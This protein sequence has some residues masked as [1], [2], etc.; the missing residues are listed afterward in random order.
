MR[1]YV[2]NLA[3]SPDRR[4]HMTAELQKVG[5]PYEFVDGV[6]GQDLD[7][8]DPQV[9]HPS[10]LKPGWPSPGTAGCAFGHLRAYE[11]IL[12]DDLD[13][14]LVL[15]D[16]VILPN[17]LADLAETVAGRMS[18]AEVAL[19]H[20]LSPNL[21]KMNRRGLVQLP[22]SRQLV[23]PV[24]VNEPGS[25]AAYIITRDACKRMAECIVPFRAHADDWGHFFNQGALDRVRCVLPF[26][27]VSEPSFGSTIGY[28]KPSG[29]K[30]RV[31][32]VAMKYEI[33]FIKR[34]I[35]YRRTRI[36]RKL[37]RF[38]L[39]DEPFIVKPTRLD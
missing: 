30:L 18:G 29:A 3:R 19:L 7:L 34:I 22:S 25:A 13:W 32:D 15:E 11:K 28:S 17:D 10:V 16:D 2:I 36:F 1:A 26:P 9:V 39:V 33:G 4:A 12:A 38:E 31:R 27:V 37:T 8:A 21:C 6:D 20:C 23:L 35:A 5:V 24:N 14:A